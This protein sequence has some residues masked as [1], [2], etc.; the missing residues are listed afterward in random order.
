VGDMGILVALKPL[1]RWLIARRPAP[2]RACDSRR[3]V[4]RDARNASDREASDR[5][6]DDG[7]A[8]EGRPS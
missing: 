3:I 8:K 7:G 2:S 1:R 4:D 6:D 5:W